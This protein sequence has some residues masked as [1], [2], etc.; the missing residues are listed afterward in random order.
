MAVTRINRLGLLGGCTVI[1]LGWGAGAQAGLLDALKPKKSDPVT[2]VTG[3][4][5]HPARP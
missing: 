4:L 2:S 1:A 3:T 5:T